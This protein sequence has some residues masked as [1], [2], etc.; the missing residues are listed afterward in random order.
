[1]KLAVILLIIIC[2][3]LLFLLFGN[4]ITISLFKRGIQNLSDILLVNA[5]PK[6]SLRIII[7]Q[8]KLVYAF[9]KGV[10]KQSGLKNLAAIVDTALID[11]II[12]N[13]ERE[14]IFQFMESLVKS[15]SLHYR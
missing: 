8:D 11:S 9:K 13:E 14:N 15:G 5:S 10:I 7:L 1:M 3:L 2:L 12:S 4:R 6:D